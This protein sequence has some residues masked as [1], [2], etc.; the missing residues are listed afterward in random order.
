VR[1]RSWRGKAGWVT[2]DAQYSEDAGP[3]KTREARRMNPDIF[4][5]D[6]ALDFLNTTVAAGRGGFGNSTERGLTRIG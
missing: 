2:T 5:N 3:P 1:Y 4:Q 6:Q